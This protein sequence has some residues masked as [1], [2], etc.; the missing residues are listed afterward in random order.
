MHF[1]NQARQPKICNICVTKTRDYVEDKIPT[2]SHD[3]PESSK[4]TKQDLKDIDV[5][6]TL[7]SRYESKN[8]EYVCQSWKKCWKRGTRFPESFWSAECFCQNNAISQKIIS[9]GNA[10]CR[11]YFLQEM[12]SAECIEIW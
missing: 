1:Q 10:F 4:A 5:L 9:A 12:L 2:T 3:P 8:P 7:K 11:K 6:C